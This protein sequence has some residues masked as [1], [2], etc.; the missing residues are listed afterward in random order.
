MSRQAQ[1][2]SWRGTSVGKALA[3][4]LSGR[5]AVLWHAEKR[6]CCSLFHKRQPNRDPG[7]LFSG[8][9][10][11][12]GVTPVRLYAVPKSVPVQRTL[13]TYIRPEWKSRLGAVT[14]N[15]EEQLP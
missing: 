13:T 1:V 7:A 5:S 14:R 9:G 3:G 12:F 2:G 6:L 10:F 11:F 8:P 15:K 4:K